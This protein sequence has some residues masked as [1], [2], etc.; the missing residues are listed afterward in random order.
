MKVLVVEDEPMLAGALVSGLRQASITVDVVHDGASAM[1]ALAEVEYDAMLLDRDLPVLHGDEVCRRCVAEHPEVGVLMLTAAGMLGDRVEGLRLGADDYLAKPFEFDE[2]VARL[3]AL[4]RRS[5]PR[6]PPQLA[7]AGLLLD[8]FTLEAFR[9]GV[10]LQLTRK[11]FSVL[12]QLMRADGGVLSAE[13]LLAKAWDEN[14]DPFTNAPRITIS[15]L[16]RK[17][18]DP[19]LIT[20]VTNGGYRLEK[21]PDDGR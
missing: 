12:E 2:L 13:A 3:R 19:W 21:G 9:D 15:N 7:V 17:M 14:A 18:G 4:A 10:R 11:E 16:R 1:N 8:P 20:T 6:R 5:G